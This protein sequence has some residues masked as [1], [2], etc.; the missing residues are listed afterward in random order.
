MASVVHPLETRN[1]EIE[2][3]PELRELLTNQDAIKDEMKYNVS[4]MPYKKYKNVESNITKK[5]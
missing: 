5:Y 1:I 2:L 4:A 3:T